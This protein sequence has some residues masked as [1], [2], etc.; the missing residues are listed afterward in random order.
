MYLF[1]FT[2]KHLRIQPITLLSLFHLPFSLLAVAG[3]FL[4][5]PGHTLLMAFSLQGLL[6]YVVDYSLLPFFLLLDYCQP[7][8]FPLYFSQLF[9][10]ISFMNSSLSVLINITSNVGYLKGFILDPSFFSSFMFSISNFN[11]PHSFTLMIMN[12]KLFLVQ[13]FILS[14][15]L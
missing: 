3:R 8:M 4:P 12:P 9:L 2:K 5:L 1:H 14:S 6:T 10:L 15:R 13:N 7:H 11:Q